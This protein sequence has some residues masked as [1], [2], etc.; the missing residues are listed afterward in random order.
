MRQDYIDHIHSKSV[1]D[2]LDDLKTLNFMV[3]KYI[4]KGKSPEPEDLEAI[5]YITNYIK[6]C[7]KAENQ[8]KAD[9]AEIKGYKRFS[10]LSIDQETERAYRVQVR[11]NSSVTYK[12]PNNF[13]WVAKS[14]VKKFKGEL[15]APVW[16]L[17]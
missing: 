8:R 4:E 12:N 3:K 1:S 13:R 7:E 5:A 14:I 6:E 16:A 2:L 15:Y 10:E 11:Y 9:E 17:R